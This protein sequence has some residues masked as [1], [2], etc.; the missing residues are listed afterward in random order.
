MTTRNEWLEAQF[1]ELGSHE[2]VLVGFHTR[3]AAFPHADVPVHH[4]FATL[5]FSPRFDTP[6]HVTDAGISQRLSFAGEAS[7][8]FVPWDCVVTL[9]S[10]WRMVS[11]ALPSSSEPPPAPPTDPSVPATPR[12]V[13]P[14]TVLQGGQA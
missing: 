2:P 6:L 5:A 13:G 11:V 1:H 7:D 14:F 9:R 4:G 12:K 3:G 8:C 10:S